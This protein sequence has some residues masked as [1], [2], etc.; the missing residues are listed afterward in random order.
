VEE[1]I[2]DLAHRLESRNMTISQFLGATGQ[3]QAAFVDGLREGAERSVK[4]DLA[5]R[6]LAEAED[7]QVSDDELA[8]YLSGL[9]TQT[10]LEVAQVRERIDRNGRLA[11]VRSQQ[12]KAKAVDWLLEHVELVDENGDPV[13]RS[14]LKL[15]GEKQPSSVDPESVVAAEGEEG[16]DMESAG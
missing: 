10:G 14:A 6:A 3:D 5:L 16:A 11:E 1:R 8:D 15:G 9:A 2:H 12:R 13:D 4:A 7:L